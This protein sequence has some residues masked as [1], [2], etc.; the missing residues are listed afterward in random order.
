MIKDKE[1]VLATVEQEKK[2]KKK[3]F[4]S[5]NSIPAVVGNG[6]SRHARKKKSNNPLNPRFLKAA[7]QEQQRRGCGGCG[8]R[9]SE[10]TRPYAGCRR[11]VPWLARVVAGDFAGWG[12][13]H[14][15]ADVQG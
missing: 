13:V 15:V 7:P 1:K 12:L 11:A 14:A 3:Q 5:S 8:N 10:E 6:L 9:R 2:K 4:P